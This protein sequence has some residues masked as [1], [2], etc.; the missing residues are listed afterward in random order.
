MRSSVSVVA[1]AMAGAALFGAPAAYADETNQGAYLD[2]LRNAGIIPGYYTSGT[3]LTSAQQLCA[4]MDSGV[5]QY[6]VVD[7]VIAA[8]GVPENVAAFVVG[9]ATVA[10]C[11]WNSMNN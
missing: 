11:P 6:H 5:D 4:T 2:A 10:F 1:L 9:T 3:A 7:A 8:D